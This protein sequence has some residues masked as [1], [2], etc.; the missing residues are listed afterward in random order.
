MV[1]ENPAASSVDGNRIGEV[2]L[3]VKNLQTYFVT[4]WGVVKAVDDVSFDLRR[5]ETLGIVGE[6]GSGKSVTVGSVMRLIPSPPGHI[7]GGQ[8]LLEGEDIL[9]L[10]EKE[11]ES[12]RGSRI[13]MVLQ[14]PMTALNPVF[15]IEDQV[16]EAMKIHRGLKGG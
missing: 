16:G 6:S 5:G 11:M 12:V 2:V 8:V 15:D 14:D 13:G 9:Q 10:D 4:R 1:S 7:V 3:E